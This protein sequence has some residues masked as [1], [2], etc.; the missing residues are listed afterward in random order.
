MEKIINT[1][2]DLDMSL[3]GGETP[4]SLSRLWKKYIYGIEPYRRKIA[5]PRNLVPFFLHCDGLLV[6]RFSHVSIRQIV[7][8]NDLEHCQI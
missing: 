2:N 4:N 8:L 1:R 6:Q 7:C 5:T 3:S